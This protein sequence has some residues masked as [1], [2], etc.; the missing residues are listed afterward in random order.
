MK[1]LSKEGRK[2][3]REMTAAERLLL[4]LLIS[5]TVPIRNLIDR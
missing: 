3:G 5:R 4:L 1:F 2:E